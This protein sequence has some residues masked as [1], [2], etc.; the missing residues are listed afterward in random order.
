MSDW[1]KYPEDITGSGVVGS[2]DE[3]TDEFLRE[4]HYMTKGQWKGYKAWCA[5]NGQKEFKYIDEDGR[6][7]IYK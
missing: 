4:C 3:E 7:I 6:T 2:T 1:N 5:G